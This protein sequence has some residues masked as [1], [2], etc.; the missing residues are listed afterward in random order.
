MLFY[1]LENVL[2]AWS[3]AIGLYNAGK[4]PGVR[5]LRCSTAQVNEFNEHR[6][7]DN[8]RVIFFYAGPSDDEAAMEEIGEEIVEQM[9]RSCAQLVQRLT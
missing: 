3:K 9:E 2:K 5:Y 4:L 7:R 1:D 6:H 8:S